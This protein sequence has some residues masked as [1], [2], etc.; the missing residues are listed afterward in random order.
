[1]TAIKGHLKTPILKTLLGAK[2]AKHNMS[3]SKEIGYI[4]I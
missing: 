1:M 4:L 2:L 3:I